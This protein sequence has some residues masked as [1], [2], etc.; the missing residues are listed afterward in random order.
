MRVT[1]RRSVLSAVKVREVMTADVIATHPDESLTDIAIR[2]RDHAVGAVAIVEGDE[3]KGI[4]TERDL[5]RATAEG[6]SPR[7]TP[8]GAYMSAGPVTIAPHE[9]LTEAVARMVDR[10]IRHLPVIDE[11]RLIGVVSARDV[12]A[13]SEHSRD[14][15]QLAYEPW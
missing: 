10:G 14:L 7:V 11:G 3:L 13:G 8:A 5:V 12:L 15:A 9:P 1:R 6:L 2:M 4:L